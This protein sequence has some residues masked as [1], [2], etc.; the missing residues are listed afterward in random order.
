MVDD[1]LY[2]NACDRAD[3]FIRKLS[4]E[5]YFEF[6]GSTDRELLNETISRVFEIAYME[7]YYKAK[8]DI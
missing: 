2:K 7:G 3:A 5:F 4:F 1:E 6:G 8:K